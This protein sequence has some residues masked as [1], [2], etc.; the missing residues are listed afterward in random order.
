M[1]RESQSQNKTVTTQSQKNQ[2]TMSHQIQTENQNPLPE[3]QQQ[4]QNS[5]SNQNQGN[6]ISEVY[7]FLA[8]PTN[9]FG[10]AQNALKT[11]QIERL[12]FFTSKL[13]PE[14]FPNSKKTFIFFA[15]KKNAC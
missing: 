2:S 14:K 8:P 6:L 15:L 10:S 4:H 13:Y 7:N 1:V 11:S 5:E 9:F 3:Y 12:E